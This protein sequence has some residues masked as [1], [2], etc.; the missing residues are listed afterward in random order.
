[1]TVL[2]HVQKRTMTEVTYFP[3]HDDRKESAEF[4]HDK[5]ELKAEGHY[6]C[7]IGNG[8]CHGE[9]QLHHSVIEFSEDNAIDWE[10]VKADYPNIDHVDDIDQMMPLCQKHHTGKYTGVH[11]TTEQAWR[12]QKYMKPEA[13]DA[14]EAEVARLI[15]ED[16]GKEAN[17]HV[18]RL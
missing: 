6:D 2:A 12:A 11:A 5:A 17:A 9:I 15:K 7:Y 14:F 18:E 1:M 4:S 8:R 13:L 10:K 16:D 3:T